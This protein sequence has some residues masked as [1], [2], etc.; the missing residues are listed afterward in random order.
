M[1]SVS[2]FILSSRFRFLANEA[3]VSRLALVLLLAVAAC[4]SAPEAD[5]KTVVQRFYNAAIAGTV[6]GAPTPEQLATLAPYLSDT[7]HALLVAARKRNETDAARAPDEKPSFA[8]GDLFSS[9]FEGPNAVEVLAD[10]ARG[11]SRVATVRM[12]YNGATPAVTWLDHVVLVRGTRGY[13]IDDVEYGG[14]WDFASK[15]TL[16]SALATALATPP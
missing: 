8:E 16:K 13:V 5:P 15:G 9:L 10:S 1:G 6:S 14:Q 3:R 2:N 12:T 11:S 7:L 4:R